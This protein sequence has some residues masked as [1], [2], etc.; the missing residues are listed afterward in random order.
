MS[1]AMLLVLAGIFFNQVTAA[2]DDKPVAEKEPAALQQLEAKQAEVE[3][4]LQEIDALEQQLGRPAEVMIRFQLLEL[5]QEDWDTLPLVADRP[6]MEGPVTGEWLQRL[7]KLK[8][9]AQVQQHIS[10]VMTTRNG[11]AVRLVNG[12]EFPIPVEQNNGKIT[13]QWR[14]FGDVVEALPVMQGEGKIDLQV[15]AEHSVRDLTHQF[16]FHG[17]PIPGVRRTRFQTQ[18]KTRFGETML[19]AH[20]EFDDRVAFL[21]VTSERVKNRP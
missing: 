20:G 17:T 14:E 5:S 2:A 6:V 12:G 9:Q 11:K 16:K 13:F 15:M 18:V 4:L 8:H 21:L 19:V 10:S 7:D 3:R 1:R